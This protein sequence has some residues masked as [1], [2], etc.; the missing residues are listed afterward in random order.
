MSAHPKGSDLGAVAPRPMT[1]PY[2]SIIGADFY[3]VWMS[4]PILMKG[5]FLSISLP[6]EG[7]VTK[8]FRDDEEII[9]EIT[10]EFAFVP[11]SIITQ[12]K[13]MR[14]DVYKNILPLYTIKIQRTASRNVYMLPIGQA[15]GFVRHME[16]VKDD[17][18]KLENEINEYYAKR[19]DETLRKV[20]AYSLKKSINPPVRSPDLVARVILDLTPVTISPEF[21]DE[22]LADEEKKGLESVRI[23]LQ[24]KQRTIIE[25]TVEELQGRL[26]KLIERLS[27]A[28]L[29][30]KIDTKQATRVLQSLTS[31]E[32]LCRDAS[33][34]SILG[35]TFRVAKQLAEAMVTEDPDKLNEITKLLA[36]DLGYRVPTN[37][38]TRKTLKKIAL[39]MSE[40][41]SP[42]VSAMLQATI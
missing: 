14:A 15:A 37:G 8:R 34:D 16:S 32:G 39:D 1:R 41:I 9:D 13:N 22:F 5:F 19:Y 4:K 38:D 18:R 30:T 6:S 10:K 17:F 21:F 24:R 3:G 25:S 7:L 33:M 42:R 27:N 26:S 28:I 31:L 40:E 29:V 11:Q 35:S 36:E 2:G 23:E 20:Q 12:F